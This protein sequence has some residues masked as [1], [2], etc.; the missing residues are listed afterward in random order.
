MDPLFFILCK[1]CRSQRGDRYAA[2]P[3]PV[4]IAFWRSSV[5]LTRGKPGLKNQ[6]PPERQ[7]R[8]KAQK[9]EAGAQRQQ[10]R[11]DHAPGGFKNE[12]PCGPGADDTEAEACE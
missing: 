7:A 9:S 5:S 2:F 8:Q 10:E 3:E 4:A 11:E 12:C 1:A 6:P